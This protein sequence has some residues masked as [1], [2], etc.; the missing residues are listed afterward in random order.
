MLHCPVLASAAVA[1]VSNHVNKTA[2]SSKTPRT[3]ADAHFT[4]T[5][6]QSRFSTRAWLGAPSKKVHHVAL[7]PHS[8]AQI[9][10]QSP[11]ILTTT[12]PPTY[13]WLCDDLMYCVYVF[14]IIAAPSL[15]NSSL[16][17]IGRFAGG[18]W[19]QK[20]KNG[21]TTKGFNGL[22]T[23]WGLQKAFWAKWLS[24]GWNV[25]IFITNFY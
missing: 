8:L 6:R 21:S 14:S 11:K 23:W 12:T 7:R 3:N 13:G 15:P 17:E 19:C 18:T 4:A 5:R 16:G 20:R 1:L 2:S 10:P 24:R 25:Y 9:Q 22:I